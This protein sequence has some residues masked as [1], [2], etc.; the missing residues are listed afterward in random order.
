VNH[1]KAS[2]FDAGKNPPR[3]RKIAV[4]GERRIEHI[5]NGAVERWVNSA[6]NVC[7]QQL[8][9]P[10]AIPSQEAIDAKRGGIRRRK[11][12]DADLAQSEDEWKWIEWHFCPMRT[13]AISAMYFPDELRAPCP[14][15]GKFTNQRT[16][17]PSYTTDLHACPHVEHVIATRQKA[18]GKRQEQLHAV[19]M[20]KLNAEAAEKAAAIAREE[21]AMAQ[22][23]QANAAMIKIAES[24]GGKKT[25][26]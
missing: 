23:E 22:Q 19:A 17:A 2:F 13:G 14:E 5:P 7:F 6:G 16:G 18:H 12:A 21:R 11:P 4:K 20:A 24:L 25:E 15:G 9:Q 10:G 3:T 8:L 26:K 1:S